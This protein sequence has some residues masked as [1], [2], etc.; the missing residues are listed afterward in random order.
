MSIDDA[1]T[2]WVSTNNRI[3]SKIKELSLSY[4]TSFYDELCIKPD[5]YFPDSLSEY[6][7]M[8]FEKEALN[9]W[10]SEHHGLGGNGASFNN[11]MIYP[12]AHVVTADEKYYKRMQK[13]NFTIL[14]GSKSSALLDVAL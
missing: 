14:A 12:H 1:M 10:M 13:N 8:P 4:A 6:L 7:G 11:L 9:Y 2:R 3:S 5:V